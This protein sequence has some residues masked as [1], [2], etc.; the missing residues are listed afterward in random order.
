MH[1]YGFIKLAKANIFMSLNL[2]LFS[3]LTCYF[4]F[5]DDHLLVLNYELYLI[6]T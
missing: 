6:I 3:P 5:F 4:I 1:L 2:Y